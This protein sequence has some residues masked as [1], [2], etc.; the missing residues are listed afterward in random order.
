MCSEIW[1]PMK[2]AYLDHLIDSVDATCFRDVH[3]WVFLADERLKSH[4]IF[5]V[6]N[7]AGR[8]LCPAYRDLYSNLEYE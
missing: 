6:Q 3:T 1:V 5:R 4:T 8:V 2:L 7:L